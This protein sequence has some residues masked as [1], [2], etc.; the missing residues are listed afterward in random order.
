MSATV[1]DAGAQSR[2]E[3]RGPMPRRIS[4][5]RVGIYAFLIISALFFLIPF[6]VMVITSL[7]EMPEI[8][9][10]NV[11]ALPQKWT[12]QPWIDAW[13]HACTGGDCS[14]LHPGFFN[15]VK[16]TVPAVIVSIG[17]SSLTGYALSFWRYKGANFFFG[18]L[19]FG[20]FVP[21]QVVIY[22]LIIALRTVHLFATLPGIIIVHTVF[23]MPILVLSSAISMSVYRSS[24]SRRRAST[25]PASGRSFCAS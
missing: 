2:D 8:L 3:P 15:S 23:G 7:K 4:P 19:V 12:V 25:V 14:G 13:L 18:L 5:G 10:G 21:Y 16:I 11:L 22:P 24:C 6:Y 20:A 9:A 1:V 17:I